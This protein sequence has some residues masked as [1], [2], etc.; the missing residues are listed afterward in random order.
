MPVYR[1]RIFGTLSLILIT[2]LAVVGIAAGSF[3]LFKA[4]KAK[5][6]VA[7]FILAHPESAVVVVYTVD[8]NGQAVADGY[9]LARGAGQRLVVAST[10]KIAV[11]AAYA[12]AVAGGEL[13]ADQVLP[14][15]DWERFYLPATDGGAH[16]S[17]LAALG[18]QADDRASPA[19]HRRQ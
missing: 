8:E 9:D 1:R 7:E 15:A 14:V 3:F 11:L 2:A 5:A 18:I 10:V 12:D 16:R 4:R 17:A 19:I 6:D 13:S